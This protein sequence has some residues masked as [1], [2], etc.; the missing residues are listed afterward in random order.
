M[1]RT[2]SERSATLLA[3][4]NGV[5]EVCKKSEFC[6]DTPYGLFHRPPLR[7]PVF[8]RSQGAAA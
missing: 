5:E 2:W 8:L 7:K 3:A 4:G 1:I 6:G